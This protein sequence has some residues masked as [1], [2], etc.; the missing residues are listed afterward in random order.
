MSHGTCGF[1]SS[2]DFSQ[3]GPIN[4]SINELNERLVNAIKASHTAALETVYGEGG[5]K[6]CEPAAVRSARD[7]ATAAVRAMKQLTFGRRAGGRRADAG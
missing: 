2:A 7:A 1:I 4:A 3:S 6:D 5:L